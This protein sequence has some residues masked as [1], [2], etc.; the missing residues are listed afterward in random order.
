M[1]PDETDEERIEKLPEDIERPFTPA[2][3]KQ[4]VNDKAP[5]TD[6]GVDSTELYQEGINS[7][8]APE[9]DVTG[10]NPEQDKRQ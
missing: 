9:N 8:T 7:P 5:E 2:A 1:Q 4:P 6:T 3:P 10:Y